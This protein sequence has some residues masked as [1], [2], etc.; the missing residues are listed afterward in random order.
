MIGVVVASTLLAQADQQNVSPTSVVPF[1]GC[2]ADGQVGPVEAP[3]GEDLK[4]PIAP[5]AVQRLSYYEALG[6]RV[7]APRG[8]HCFGVYGSG[9]ETLF[10][11]PLVIGWDNAYSDAVLSAPVIQV[12]RDF[13][14]GGPGRLSA[15]LAVARVFPAHRRFAEDFVELFDM[16]L[17]FGPY[18]A[19]RLTYI[20][21]EVVEYETP[22]Q[23]E[24]LGTHNR[25]KPGALPIRGVAILDKNT[26][27]LIH[28]AVR[29]P[30][31]LAGLA[32]VIIEQAKHDGPT[33]E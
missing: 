24:G 2:A 14:G 15:A 4:L 32:P 16:D 29:L 9:G 7:L 13:S 27:N 6:L 23:A 20:N 3:T 30:V 18:P 22:A 19:D 31:D 11:S 1:V 10:V 21:D 26:Y 25:L 5:E 12:N 33:I 17:T 8:W 28:L